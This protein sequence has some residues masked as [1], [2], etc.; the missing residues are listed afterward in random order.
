MDDNVLVHVPVGNFEGRSGWLC[1]VCSRGICRDARPW[2]W[3]GCEHCLR[4]D[5][6]VAGLLGARRILPLGQHSIMNNLGLDLSETSET[7]QSAFCDQL[8]AMHSGWDALDAW[9][10]AQVT[11]LGLALGVELVDG[12]GA[13]SL[14]TWRDAYPSTSDA[15]ATAYLA[16]LRA[17]DPWV[18]DINP[19]ICDVDWL[20]A[21]EVQ[22]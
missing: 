2:S 20:V 1:K 15:S 14:A 11:E 6:K 12:I 22:A 7:V 3:F 4:V 18:L 13:L 10:Y 5:R 19:R 9:S 17:Q 16:C 8:L 21:T